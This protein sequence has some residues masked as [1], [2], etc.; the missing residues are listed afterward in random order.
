MQ[1]RDVRFQ[2][3][4]DAGR[5]LAGAVAHLRPEAPVVLG[6][7]RGG[8]VVAAEVAR[9]LQAPLDVVIVRK[10]GAPFQPEYAIG[11]IGEAGIVL[12]D[13]PVVDALELRDALPGLIERERRELQRRIDRYRRGRAAVDVRGR[14]VVLVDDGIATGATARVAADVTRLRGAGRIV[15]AVPVGPRDVD[16]RFAGHVDELVCLLQP[17]DFRAVGSIYGAFEATEDEEVERLLAEAE[18]PAGPAP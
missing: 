13:D 11:A 1:R 4:R 12:I 5:A 8:V 17:R 16:E 6:L 15:L 10:L 14:T 7:P 9:A 2:D 3:R 18:T